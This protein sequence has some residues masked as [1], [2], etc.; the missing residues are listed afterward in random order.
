M[1]WFRKTFP[2]KAWVIKS[3]AEIRKNLRLPLGS[4][5][6]LIGRNS[7]NK[8]GLWNI[9]KAKNLPDYNN[10]FVLHEADF[11]TKSQKDASEIIINDLAEKEE[12]LNDQL[13]YWEEVL[14]FMEDN[15][16]TEFNDLEYKAYRVLQTIDKDTPDYEK[17]KMIAE[18]IDNK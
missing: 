7:K 17:A 16:L 2:K 11:T 12:K 15:S 4:P 5:I 1:G 3:E 13:E 9:K 10:T 8:D 14:K 6:F 18:I